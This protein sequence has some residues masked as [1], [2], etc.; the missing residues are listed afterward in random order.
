MYPSKDRMIPVAL[1]I[2]SFLVTFAILS[3]HEGRWPLGTPAV[4][5]GVTSRLEKAGAPAQP[6]PPSRGSSWTAT[7][8]PIETAAEEAAPAPSDESALAPV[9]ATGYLAERSR[10]TDHSSRAR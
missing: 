6:T 7:A 9:D 10:E 8:P 1:A 4:H 3:W 5:A 2:A